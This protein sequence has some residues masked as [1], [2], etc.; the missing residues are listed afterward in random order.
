MSEKQ[1][2][3]WRR[4]MHVVEMKLSAPRHM[5]SGAAYLRPWIR[6]KDDPSYRYQPFRGL[7]EA[8]RQDKTQLAVS[9]IQ[10]A[11]VGGHFVLR[12]LKCKK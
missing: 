1:Q 9:A 6:T 11:S 2:L 5:K 7:L 3:K 4:R 8:R 10:D 12:A